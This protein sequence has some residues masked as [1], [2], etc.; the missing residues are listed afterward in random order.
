MSTDPSTLIGKIAGLQE[1]ERSSP[2]S[3]GPAA[4][5]ITWKWFARIP[6]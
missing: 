4:S 2:R 6:L 1:S 3:T 5:R